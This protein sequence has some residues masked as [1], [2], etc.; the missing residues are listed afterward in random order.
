[1]TINLDKISEEHI[2]HNEEGQRLV[3]LNIVENQR[4]WSNGDKTWGFVA[5]WW[6]GSAH[7]ECPILGSVRMFKQNDQQAPSKQPEDT[8]SPF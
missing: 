8:G 5:Q 1:V 7:G 6:R 2:R 4:T 3:D